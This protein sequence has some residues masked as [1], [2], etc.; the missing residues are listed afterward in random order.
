[1]I[2]GPPIKKQTLEEKRKII[3]NFDQLRKVYNQWA[4]KNSNIAGVLE[5]ENLLAQVQQEKQFW[6][7][8]STSLI[9][10]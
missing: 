10:C 2:S 3:K 9:S 1:M 5:E 4:E 6:T 8:P 7:E